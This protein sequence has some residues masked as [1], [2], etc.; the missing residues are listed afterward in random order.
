MGSPSADT[1][2]IDF[3]ESQFA[4]EL[5]T[6]HGGESAVERAAR[7]T[8][9]DAR[10][11]MSAQSHWEASD[12]LLRPRSRFGA[13]FG[14]TQT[15]IRR[16]S[17]RHAWNTPDLGPLGSSTKRIL[18]VLVALTVLVILLPALV[19][20]AAAIKLESGGSVLYRQERVGRFGESFGMLRFRTSRHDSVILPALADGPDREGHLF[21]L[22]QM[23]STTR[24]G[25][26][27][28][29]YS[30]D[31]LPQFVNVMVGDMSLVGARPPLPR[32]LA[33]FDPTNGRASTLR[34]GIT[35]LWQIS[36]RASLSWE[37][38]Q[39][40]EVYYIE[41]WTPLLDLAISAR[42]IAAVMRGA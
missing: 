29:R 25:R 35:G 1:A 31:E 23:S 33:R 21:K 27:L 4:G 32:E 17:A 24:V 20:I 13:L 26:F 9:E 6:E 10:I 12:R 37:E 18:D 41:N 36:G 40:F 39:R 14:V 7:A 5:D 30:M 38:S 3:L 34:P 22:H 19:A 8:M 15:D 2:Y 42:T 28:R 11:T 16:A